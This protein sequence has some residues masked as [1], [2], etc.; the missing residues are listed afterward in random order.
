MSQARWRSEPAA[1]TDACID[2]SSCVFLWPRKKPLLFET[3]GS[4]HSLQQKWIIS[5]WIKSGYSLHR[6]SPL[7]SVAAVTLHVLSPRQNWHR[8]QPKRNIQEQT[9]TMWLLQWPTSTTNQPMGIR[10]EMMQDARADVTFFNKTKKVIA[11]LLFYCVFKAVQ[12]DG[13]S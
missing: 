7:N 11:C 2:R 5:R 8:Q 6:L 3:T 1:M 4:I 9:V 12:T 10:H 13:M